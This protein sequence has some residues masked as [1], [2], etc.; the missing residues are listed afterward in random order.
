LDIVISKLFRGRERVSERERKRGGKNAIERE[1]RKKRS[2][3]KCRMKN[4]GGYPGGKNAIKGKTE[5]TAGVICFT[6]YA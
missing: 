2:R 6:K 4:A 3:N 5:K 1:R